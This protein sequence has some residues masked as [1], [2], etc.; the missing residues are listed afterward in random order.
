[1]SAES[2]ILAIEHT[3]SDAFNAGKIETILALFD[4]ELIGFSSTQHER[5]VGI[6][7]L[8]ETFHFYLKEADHLEYHMISPIIKILDEK[9]AIATFYWLVILMNGKTRREIQG[10]G[11]HVFLKKEEGWKIIH[12]HF[13]R[14]FHQ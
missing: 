7:A 5:L 13:S 6:N 1:M 2:E 8:R 11:T 10:R 3:M 4:E 12:E 9:V 14:S